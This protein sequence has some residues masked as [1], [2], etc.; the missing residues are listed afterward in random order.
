M[1]VKRSGKLQNVK[2]K[3]ENGTK[4]GLLLAGDL[5]AQRATRKAPIDTGRLKRS[6]T[7]SNPKKSGNNW[8]VTIGTNVKY[9]AAQEF[10][11]GLHSTRRSK[12]KIRITP[13]NKKALAFKWANAPS[14]LEPSKSG[15]FLFSSVMHPGVKAQPYLRPAL[16]ESREDATKIIGNAIVG[17]LTSG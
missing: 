10:G 6:I 3:V 17:A 2:A 16:E 1:P 7:R 14:G 5:I 11:S 15:K 9:A 4:N 13:K 8:S 12:Q